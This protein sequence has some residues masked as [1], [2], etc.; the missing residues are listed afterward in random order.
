MERP[1]LGTVLREWARIG[2][3]GFGGPPA[4]IRLLRQLTVE[5]R[6]WVGPAEFEDAVATC[7][8][9][10]GPSSTQLAIFTA[11]RV[12]GAPGA[13]VGG[14]AFILPGLV[15]I[16]ALSML[17]LG[18]SPPE[19]VL[20]AG[21]G[22]GAA[23]PAVAVAAGWALVPSSW[24]R[25]ASRWRWTVYAAVGV[26]ASALLGPWVVLALLGCGVVEL[27]WQHPVRATQGVVA[28]PMLVKGTA[29]AGVLLPLTWTAFKVGALSY[30]GGFVIIP[31]MQADAVDQ[32]GWMSSADFLNAVVLGQITPGPVVHTVAVV[33][34]AAAGLVGGIL[35]AVVAFAPSFVFIVAG[36]RHF[37][38]LRADP[39]MRTF[40]GGAGPAAIGAIV[41]SAVPLLRALGEPWQAAV[42]VGAGV[43]LLALHRGVVLTLLL[44]GGLGVV[45]ALAGTPLP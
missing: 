12:R 40:L 1:L 24:Q 34:F 11:W 14:A 23:V 4:H 5:R 8:L 19:W 36:G 33:G 38:L 39:W 25:T 41:G 28:W 22:A 44:A 35:A 29:G 7:N 20:G 32:R 17:F 31:L 16:L 45:L 43:L 15:L 18:G 6:G 10:P 26:A 42:A 37:D 9:L 3:I 2:C 30:G 21:A 27:G 13:L